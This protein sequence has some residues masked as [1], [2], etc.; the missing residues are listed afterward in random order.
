MSVQV[1]TVLRE[2]MLEVVEVEA[3]V[4]LGLLRERHE[5]A[6]QE[7]SNDE[8]DEGN[9]VLEGAPDALA[10]RL[11]SMLCRVLVVFLVVEVG[12]GHDDQAEQGV[13]RVERVVDNL[14]GVDD[15][16]DLVGRGPVLLLAQA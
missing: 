9:G 13:E 11:F 4:V 7:E 3:L 12:K 10:G 14:Q 2:K 6:N 5:E 8:D 1:L 15:V 16:V